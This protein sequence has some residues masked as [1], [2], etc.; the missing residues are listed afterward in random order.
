VKHMGAGSLADRALISDKPCSPSF[1]HFS[2]IAGSSDIRERG[3]PD[4]EQRLAASYTQVVPE[5][6]PPPF[7]VFPLVQKFN[8]AAKDPTRVAKKEACT[9]PIDIVGLHTLI[10]EDK[11]PNLS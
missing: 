4:S 3:P 5:R 10:V 7:S 11:W 6:Q 9:K 8:R 2:R 1:F